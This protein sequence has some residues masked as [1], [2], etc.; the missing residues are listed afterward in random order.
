MNRQRWRRK[1]KNQKKS[2]I[3][4]VVI[5]AVLFISYAGTAF[6]YTAYT[7]E[8]DFQAAINGWNIEVLD[9]DSMSYGTTINSGDTIDGITFTY[10]N[11]VG[12]SMMIS[13]MWDTTSPYNYLSTTDYLNYYD[14]FY[15]GDCFSLS[16]APVNAIGMYFI[17]PPGSYYPWDITL[18]V[19]NFTALLAEWA[20]LPLAD[21]SWAFF[22]GIVD[23]QNAF[24]QA[25]IFTVD[26]SY[27]PYIVD[28]ITTAAVP[29]PGAFWLLG[30]GLV[31]LV[32]I[33][34]KFKK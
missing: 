15:F 22:L 12:G 2:V 6:G 7:S 5:V 27:W 23:D 26:A 31:G 24:T 8:S 30:S 4:L 32:G 11:L 14:V 18:T 17:V 28:D 1:M 16:F 33:R 20:Y 34:K 29:I 10:N 25:D 3:V 13:H 19:D 9:F 21:D